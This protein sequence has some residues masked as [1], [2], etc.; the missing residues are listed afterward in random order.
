MK[1]YLL[2][3]ILAASAFSMRAEFNKLVFHTLTGGEQ[4][5]GLN[6]LNI[7]F[8]NGQLLATADGESVAIDLTEMESMEFAYVDPSG[9]ADAAIEGAFTAYSAEGISFGKF[10]SKQAAAQALP[11]GLYIVKSESGITSKLLINR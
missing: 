9:I 10:E 4:S 2:F 11:S 1:K 6:G 3:A 7:T 8:A 5:V